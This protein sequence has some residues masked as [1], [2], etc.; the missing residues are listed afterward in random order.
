MAITLKVTPE[1][2]T[3]KAGEMSNEKTQIHNLMEQAKQQ[4]TGLA[5]SWE[6]QASTEYRNRFS[7][8]YDDIDNMLAVAQEHISDLEEAARIYSTAE[9]T[10]R[11]AAEGLP[12]QGVF[13]G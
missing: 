5:A 1:V 6:S 7:Q 12:T 11:T 10:A 8:C 3:A 13:N 4:I 2:L 9:S